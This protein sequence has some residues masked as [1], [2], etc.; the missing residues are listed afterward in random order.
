[1]D[2]AIQAMV[3]STHETCDVFWR[4]HGCDLP[5]GHD[6]THMCCPQLGI[7]DRCQTINCDDDDCPDDHLCHNHTPRDDDELYLMIQTPTGG[8]EREYLP[9]VNEQ[10]N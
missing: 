6:G 5:A 7:P 2:D 1:M 4:S 10:V 9:R 8:W 3:D